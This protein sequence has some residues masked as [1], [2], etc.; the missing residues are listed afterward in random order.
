MAKRYSLPCKRDLQKVGPTSSPTSTSR[1]GASWINPPQGPGDQGHQ[2]CRRHPN[3]SEKQ[4]KCQVPLVSIAFPK[5]QSGSGAPAGLPS[6]SWDPVTVVFPSPRRKI[7]LVGSLT[8]DLSWLPVVEI[9]DGCTHIQTTCAW[10]F[11]NKILKTGLKSQV[12]WSQVTGH[13]ECRWDHK[14]C[15]GPDSEPNAASKPLNLIMSM[16][17]D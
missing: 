17:L 15:F 7:W 14:S 13:M 8:G 1:Y 12:R 16:V 9:V 4:N 6:L 10:G 5:S 3:T 11:Y 2:C